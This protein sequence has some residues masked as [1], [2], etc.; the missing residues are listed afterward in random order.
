MS[1]DQILIGG[2]T[3]AM[4]LAGLYKPVWLL[5]HTEK[6]RRLVRWLGNSRALWLLRFSLAAGLGFGLLLAMG[7]INPVRY[8]AASAQK[9]P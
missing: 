3:A 7:V 5:Q 9:S 4:C 2:T 1:H 6:G 8:P